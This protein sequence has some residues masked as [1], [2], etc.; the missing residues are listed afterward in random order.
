MRVAIHW[1]RHSESVSNDLG[2]NGPWYDQWKQLVLHDVGLSERGWTAAESLPRESIPE[3]Q[4]VV[5]S[6]LLRAIETAVTLYPLQ[7]VHV[8]CG[9]SE[10]VPGTVN[11]ADASAQQLAQLEQ[12]AGSKKWSTGNI[13]YGADSK[14]CNWLACVDGVHFRRNLARLI[15]RTVPV[16]QLAVSVAVVGH[17]VWMMANLGLDRMRN[18]EMRQT[19]ATLTRPAV[20]L[21]LHR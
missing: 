2:Q 14:S 9:N 10:L 11:C 21:G 5:S 13:E 19:V 8:L 18:L 12:I 6:H 17:S 4:L 15:L 20:Y 1:I 16:T 3:V 7:K